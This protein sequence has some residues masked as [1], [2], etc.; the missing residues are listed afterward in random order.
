VPERSDQ[1]YAR[2]AAAIGRLRKV[3]RLCTRIRPQNRRKVDQVGSA[4]LPRC[5]AE[6][7]PM[8]ERER[9]Q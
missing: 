9:D 7:D 5:F 2:K 1:L 8:I 4:I 3:S 6:P